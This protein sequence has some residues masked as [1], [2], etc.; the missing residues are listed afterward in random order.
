M[1]SL[2]PAIASAAGLSP[3]KDEL[4]AYPA[5]LSAGDGGTHGTPIRMTDWRD[6][7]NWMLSVGK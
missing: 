6:T 1:L 4:F 5:T 7:L 3:F 2:A